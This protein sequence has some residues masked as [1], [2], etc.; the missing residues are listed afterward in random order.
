MSVVDPVKL[1]VILSSLGHDDSLKIVVN[2]NRAVIDDECCAQ[3]FIRGA[4]LTGGFAAKPDKKYHLEILTP[5]VALSRQLASLLSEFDLP[6]KFAERAGHKALY[7]KSSELI[8][9]FFT[10]CGAPLCAMKI[11]ETKVEKDVRNNV[12]RKVNCETAN[13]VK[14]ANAAVFQRGMIERL[15][16]RP[17]W[18]ELPGAL[19]DAAFMR[20]E[21]PEDTLRELAER[22]G[23]SKSGMNHRIR[24]LMELADNE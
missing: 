11:M 2:L 4:F 23:V 20:L 9:D 13:T 5:H 7:Y 22:A 15:M 12:N 18:D 1:K 17:E 24:Q 14:T 21:Y 10:L 16:E 6:P 3:A 8:E 19:R